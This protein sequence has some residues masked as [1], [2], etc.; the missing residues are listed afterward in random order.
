MPKGLLPPGQSPR[1]GGS[2][3]RKARHID[4]DR[5]FP[6]AAGS[7]GFILHAAKLLLGNAEEARQCSAVAFLQLARAALADKL[8][9]IGRISANQRGQ[10]SKA[11]A[12]LCG[13][14][15]QTAARI[16]IMHG[17]NLP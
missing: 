1:P 2:I 13:Q 15:D 3:E 16:G 11:G 4:P 14:C 12:A 5:G 8:L 9:E 6:L 7:R 10:G 17:A